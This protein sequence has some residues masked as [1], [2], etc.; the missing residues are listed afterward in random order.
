MRKGIPGALGRILSPAAHFPPPSTAQLLLSLRHTDMWGQPGQ[1]PARYPSRWRVEPTCRHSLLRRNDR[2]ELPLA[3]APHPVPGM[4]TRVPAADRERAIT[5]LWGLFACARP[6]SATAR[7][8]VAVFV[9]DRGR[10]LFP[11]NPVSPRRNQ[12]AWLLYGSLCRDLLGLPL[13]QP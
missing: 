3:L 6:I 2:A 10:L 8:G 12:L 13:S 7:A 1:P 11:P 5:A 9:G 4:R